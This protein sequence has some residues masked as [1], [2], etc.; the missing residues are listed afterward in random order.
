MTLN[1]GYHPTDWYKI[2]VSGEDSNNSRLE[3]S[4]NG[5]ILISDSL[6]DG[7]FIE[8]SN[9]TVKA[10]LGVIVDYDS[11]YIYEIDETHIGIKLD[12][13]NNGTY[14]TDFNPQYVGDANQDGTISITDIVLFQKYLLNITNID[15]K[16]YISMDMNLDGYVNVIDLV[17]A[18]KCLLES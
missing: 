1:D 16:Q 13:D 12:T 14:E 9:R 2:S 8:T 3:I 11:V 4:G 5:Y 10:N 18:K 7:I 15:K 6:S 17:L